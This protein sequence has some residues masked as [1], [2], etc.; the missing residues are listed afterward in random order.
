M[1]CGIILLLIGLAGC[2]TGGGGNIA[3]PV[4][5]PDSIPP[6]PEWTVSDGI[7]RHLV[8]IGLSTTAE[9]LACPGADV[10]AWTVY[11]W[12][13]D[14]QR[15]ILLNSQATRAAVKA[16]LEAAAKG[17]GP[18]D[19]LTISTSGHGTRRVDKD[20]DEKSGYDSGL[21]LWDGVWWDDDIWL[22]LCAMPPCR[23]ELITDNC[24][25]EGN[26]RVVGRALTLGL[27][28]PRQYVQ[29]ELPLADAR[30]AADWQGQLAQ[31]AGSRDD[32]YSYGA[33]A[34]GTWTQALDAKLRY[35][36]T[37]TA[38]FAAAEKVMPGQQPP[39]FATYNA[40][41]EF[42]AGAFME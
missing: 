18:E 6:A 4:T 9:A 26:W 41:P 24:Y 10:D 35:G 3:A 30:A 33:P 11:A 36:I 25:A 7:D 34:G 27:A 32:D 28:F 19:L 22:F 2:T 12:G 16:M 14:R 17:M 37:R 42:L 39:V 38:F 40:S 29:L 31:W 5:V 15:A 13:H 1:K 8:C 21:V 20:G 23:V